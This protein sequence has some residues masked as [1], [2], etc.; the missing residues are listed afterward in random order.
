MDG[1]GAG[2]AATGLIATRDTRCRE[3][4]RDRGGFP[5]PWFEHC[6]RNHR[7]LHYNVFLRENSSSIYFRF[8]VVDH[9]SREEASV[10]LSARLVK[11]INDVN[12]GR[13]ERQDGRRH[14]T[15]REAAGV[16]NVQTPRCGSSSRMACLGTG[17]RGAARAM[18]LVELPSEPSVWSA[19]QG[20]STR[21]RVG[22][23]DTLPHAHVSPDTITRPQCLHGRCLGD[24]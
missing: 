3:E 14:E 13:Y 9:L 6:A 19:N 24:K 11:S 4:G 17:Q 12:M 8:V 1:R 21:P 15:G 23:L 20:E 16:H 2:D 10:E 18:K 7:L 22:R 5:R